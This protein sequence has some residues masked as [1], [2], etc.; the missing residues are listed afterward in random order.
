M[1]AVSVADRLST[2]PEIIGSC[3]TEVDIESHIG[4]IGYIIASDSASGIQRYLHG[5]IAAF[6]FGMIAFAIATEFAAVGLR[7]KCLSKQRK[8]W[9]RTKQYNFIREVL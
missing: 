6:R 8:D 9:T 1:N 5:R 4:A 3:E 7:E 2:Q